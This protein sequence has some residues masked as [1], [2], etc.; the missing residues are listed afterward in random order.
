MKYKDTECIAYKDVI[1]DG[2]KYTAVIK[3][4]TPYNRSEIRGGVYTVTID[5]FYDCELFNNNNDMVF[6]DEEEEK[7]EKNYINVIKSFCE[8]Y[9]KYKIREI[10]A[11]EKEKKILE[12]ENLALKELEEWDGII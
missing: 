10:K 4:I 1:I 5:L 3:D 12:E 6:H 9:K 7:E 2:E 11:M 8:D